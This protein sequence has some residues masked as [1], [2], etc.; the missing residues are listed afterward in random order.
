MVTNPNWMAPFHIARAMPT[1]CVLIG[2]STGHPA[3]DVARATIAHR[4]KRGSCAGLAQD[5]ER[6][7]AHERVRAAPG[8]LE[9]DRMAAAGREVSGEQHLAIG[10]GRGDEA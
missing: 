8:R 2:A 4:R 5:D 7:K 1:L 3:R 6:I 10:A 9:D